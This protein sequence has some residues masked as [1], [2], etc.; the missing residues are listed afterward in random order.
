MVTDLVVILQ[1]QDVERRLR[2]AR[3]HLLFFHWLW[4]SESCHLSANGIA[5]TAPYI[6]L[7]PD[8]ISLMQKVACQG[9][10]IM[11]LLKRGNLTNQLV[12]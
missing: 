5:R 12:R 10:F 11:W 9:D 2:H 4:S 7:R 6:P 1:L 3:L 8:I